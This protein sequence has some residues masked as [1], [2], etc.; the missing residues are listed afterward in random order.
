MKTT[1]L[2][3]SIIFTITSLFILF[4]QLL[5]MKVPD[6]II[7]MYAMLFASRATYWIMKNKKK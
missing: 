5:I 6:L 7:T 2:K 1:E 4:F 3:E